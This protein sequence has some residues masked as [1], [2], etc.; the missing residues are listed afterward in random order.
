MRSSEPEAIMV[1]PGV[2]IER[3]VYDITEHAPNR[4]GSDA[5]PEEEPDLTGW[6][7]HEGKRV[8][9]ETGFWGGALIWQLSDEGFSS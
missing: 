6:I 8:P 5:D 9:V 7:R 2:F 3:V 4:F 1:S